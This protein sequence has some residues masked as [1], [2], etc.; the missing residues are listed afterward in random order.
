MLG[1]EVALSAGETISYFVTL[2]PNKDSFCLQK[3]FWINLEDAVRAAQRCF[4]STSQTTQIVSSATTAL[5]EV[6]GAVYFV[7]ILIQPEIEGECYKY[8]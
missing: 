3:L 6:E 4:N 8:P 7:R 2:H 1:N 5:T